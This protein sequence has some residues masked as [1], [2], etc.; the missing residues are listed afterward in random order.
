MKK[1]LFFAII[2]TAATLLASCD[3]N[4]SDTPAP[5]APEATPALTI[6]GTV[7]PGL[8]DPSDAPYTVRGLMVDM[9]N[10]GTAGEYL[11]PDVFWFT[12]AQPVDENRHFT[13]TL[14][15]TPTH[16]QLFPV[17]DLKEYDMA[18]ESALT[19]SN[20]EANVGI[21]TA[22]LF[23]KNGGY[24]VLIPISAPD[25]IQNFTGITSTFAVYSDADCAVSGTYDALYIVWWIYPPLQ[26]LIESAPATVSITAKKGWNAVE[27]SLSFD[28]TQGLVVNIKSVEKYVESSTDWGYIF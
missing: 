14:P 13:L 1:T 8:I 24:N 7:T 26:G 9:Y 18:E 4:G 16:Q 19:I 15:E 6:S 3:K 20:E 22:M 2:A 10:T 21:A 28:A 11:W 27:L 25:N 23:D 5:E 17:T 12:D